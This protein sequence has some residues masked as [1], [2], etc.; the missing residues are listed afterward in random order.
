MARAA[1]ERQR[2]VSLP[3]RGTVREGALALPT[4]AQL[5]P[6]LLLAIP[7][8]FNL[9]SLRSE[10]TAVQNVNDGHL[11]FAMVRWARAQILHGNIIPVDNWFP[12]LGLGGA[13]FRHYSDLGHILTAYVSVIAGATT[14]YYWSLY[15]LLA[16]WP[17]SVYFGARLLGWDRWTAAAA[18][19]CAPLLASAMNYGYERG[20][21]TWYGLGLWAQIWGMWL[22]PIALGLTW[23]AVRGTGSY[24]L[25]ALAVALTVAGHY[26]E[27]YLALLAIGL[28]AVLTPSQLLP[29]MVRAIALGIGSLVAAAWTI[30]P[31]FQDSHFLLVSEYDRGS[32]FTLSFGAPKVLGWLV[33]G[34]IYDAGRSIPTISL[35][36]G[37]GLLVC[38]MRFRR[39][40]RARAVVILWLACLL[41]FF[42][43]PTLGRVLDFLPGGSLLM[44]HRFIMG[45]HFS[46]LLL[47]GIGAVWLGQQLVGLSRRIVPSIRPTLA[48]AAAVSLLVLAL[49]P[50]WTAIAA[51]DNAG[52]TTSASQQL[53][54]STDG[55][56]LQVLIDSIKELSPG[57][58]Y[59]GP[60]W[61]WGSDYRVGWVPVFT[62]LANQDIDTVGFRFRVDSLMSDAE[63]VF[64]E[65][66][67]ADY[68]L[69]GIRYLLL[70]ADR[71]PPI[72]ATLLAQQG[73]HTLWQVDTSGYFDV[74]D[75]IWP[76]VVEDHGNIATHAL[77]FVDSPQ[78]AQHQYPTVAF[79]GADA[80]APTLQPG[81]V[82]Q[83]A[84]GQVVNQQISLIDGK[85]RADV[86]A[87]RT[88]AVLLKASYD[89]RWRVTVDGVQSRP[90][91]V[92]PALMAATVPAGHHSVIFRYVPD[93][94]YPLLFGLGLL[95]LLGLGI[96]PRLIPHARRNLPP[97]LR[98]R[99]VVGGLT[100][101]ESMEN[102]LS[103]EYQPQ[104]G[105][106]PPAPLPKT[107]GVGG[108]DKLWVAEYRR[109]LEDALRGV[110][111]FLK[112][113]EAWALHEA[114]RLYPP[115]SEAVTVMEIGSWKGRST[116][117]LALGVQERGNGAVY[118]IDPHT[119]SRELIEMFGPVD[120]YGAFLWNI[121]RA[122][123]SDI[124]VPV[125]K[126]AHHARMTVEEKSVH[127]LFVDGSHEY[128]D[129][130]QD[131]DD[132]VTAL[133][134][135]ATVSFN[136]PSSPGVY[137]ALRERVV[138]VGSPFRSP[139]LIQNSLF[140]E[141][142]RD[143]TNRD[144]I[145][146]LRL[147]AALALRYQAERVRPYTPTWFV[148]FGNWVLRRTLG[149]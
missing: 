73:R 61:G 56:D 94:E 138:V 132:W 128:E 70:P 80:A 67:P 134:D 51:Q 89:P 18:A 86:F 117:A 64:D 62:V 126:T 15:L 32:Y 28:W 10:T 133:A 118:A 143:A 75:T 110:E 90:Y 76:P 53:W 147:R 25:A 57:R 77:G 30:V 21:Y 144:W 108:M 107:V 60:R 52:A 71:K 69:Y 36:V 65:N 106:K 54:D 23:R 91:M 35:L 145:A 99:V 11:H 120:T 33:T 87:N 102:Q 26:M 103:S 127:V 82:P 81:V 2:D 141:F 63:M 50:A 22:L 112:L 40:E 129:V 55:A 136:D 100:K 92:A 31:V 17:L 148:R 59:A 72:P 105:E 58:V 24:W 49:Y 122:G 9:W 119:G 130:R 68:E 41:L 39:D 43:R 88:A 113:D 93:A 140:F 34:Q 85:Y 97:A 45:V 121:E 66:N 12:Y 96:G 142:N 47:A 146:F 78:L 13:Q 6:R 5:G 137:R 131:I 42:G 27:G 123:V 7:I 114:A 14:T 38:L 48:A 3:L 111:G 4:L 83:G 1:V 104:L 8:L 124:V 20:S 46:G 79:N 37:V 74:V 16:L 149:R 44:Y 98:G 101:E 115:V 135:R 125:R 139:R 116:I 19:V 109:R 95:A 84:A 29:R